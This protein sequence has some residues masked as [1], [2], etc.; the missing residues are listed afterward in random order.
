MNDAGLN[1]IDDPAEAVER[2]LRFVVAEI[3]RNPLARRITVD[4]ETRQRLQDYR[5]DEKRASNHRSDIQFI[6]SVVDPFIEDGQFRSQDP[7]VVAETIAAIPYL[8][9]H[10]DEIGD[11]DA[12]QVIDFI[13]ETFA[14][15]LVDGE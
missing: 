2:L 14:R 7:E 11:D 10:R 5:S 6:R 1:E 12:E 13:V 8:T 9:L 15:G 3:D 4:P